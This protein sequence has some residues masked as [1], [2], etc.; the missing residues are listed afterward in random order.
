MNLE[1]L[2]VVIPAHNE[3]LGIAHA[4][5][6]IGKF[7][8]LLDFKDCARNKKTSAKVECYGPWD[9]YK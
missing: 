1:L 3:A 4:L 9:M 5:D 7:P 8:V 2:T 6:V